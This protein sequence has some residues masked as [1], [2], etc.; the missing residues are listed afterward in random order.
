MAQ[1]NKAIAR[2]N[3]R[4][5][6]INREYGHSIA[7]LSTDDDVELFNGLLDKLEEEL[8]HVVSGIV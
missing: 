7:R 8:S 2:A 4:I 5:N 3:K 1:T 6:R